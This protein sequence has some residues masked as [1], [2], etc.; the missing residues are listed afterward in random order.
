MK[1]AR[2][3]AL[4]TLLDGA[5]YVSL[6]NVAPDENGE[7]VLLL[8]RLAWHTRNIERDPRVC[9]LLTA[10]P[11]GADLLEGSRVSLL[12]SL[13]RDDHP[14]ARSLYLTHHPQ[15]R[16]YADF[17]DF[18]FYRLELAMAH[19]VAGFGRIVTLAREEL[20]GGGPIEAQEGSP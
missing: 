3:G 20:F 15:A 11:A 19:Y 18:G 4:A 13:A 1:Q 16:R 12:G 14:T 6:V 7:S 10:G 5:P 8:S 9:L 2:S 17:G